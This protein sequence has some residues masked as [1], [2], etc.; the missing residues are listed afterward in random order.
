MAVKMGIGAGARAAQ[1][2]E[3]TLRAYLNGRIDVLQAEAVNDLIRAVTPAQALVSY[4]QVSGTLSR[5]IRAIRDMVLRLVAQVEASIEFPEDGLRL[6]PRKHLRSLDRL[7]AELERLV[8]SYERGKA[9]GGNLTLAIVGSPN[10]GKSTLFNAFL[11]EDRAI[12]T[13][14]PGTTRDYLRER[15]VI[16]D[17]VFQIVDMAG[18]GSPEHPIEREG[19]AKGRKIAAEADGLILVLD[20][21]RRVGRDDQSL[22]RRYSGRKCIHILNKCDLPRRASL[23]RIRALAGEG[24]LLEVSA[25]RGDGLKALRTALYESFVPSRKVDEE[26][27]LHR[28][29]KDILEEILRVVRNTA[30]MIE[31]GHSEE[32][33]AEEIRAAL[34]LMGRLIGEIRTDDVMNEIFGRF[35]VG[36]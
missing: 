3:F 31:G 4:R 22:L 35:C 30:A 20:G 28:R 5:K 25:L 10:V 34:P 29:Q 8:G 13:P 12:V 9:L 17:A 24:P 1:P 2:G 19:M 15:V 26:T 11:G 36:K 33:I 16:G 21:S 14:Y 18:L 7:G 32:I 27:I 6:S 23:T